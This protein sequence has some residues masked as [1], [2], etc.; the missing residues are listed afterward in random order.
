MARA[1]TQSYKRKFR[2]HVNALTCGSFT[3]VRTANLRMVSSTFLVVA[4][5]MTLQPTQ[6]CRHTKRYAAKKLGVQR[7]QVRCGKELGR[8]LIVKQKCFV[9][10]NKDE[11]VV[12]RC[13]RS[14]GGNSPILDSGEDNSNLCELVKQIG[15]QAKTFAPPYLE[16]TFDPSTLPPTYEVQCAASPGFDMLSTPSV[17]WPFPGTSKV[18]IL[19]TTTTVPIMT[20]I[21]PSTTYFVR[22]SLRPIGSSSVD[23]CPIEPAN[24]LSVTT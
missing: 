15:V 3:L 6:G 2:L 1:G 23:F 24:P 9:K 14:P 18:T 20:G 21:N 5:L 17:F 22:C 8:G 19:S 16:I 4:L 10:G 7:N 11:S 12:A 13:Y